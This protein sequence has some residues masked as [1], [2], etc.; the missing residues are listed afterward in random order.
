M[1]FEWEIDYINLDDLQL[2]LRLTYGSKHTIPMIIFDTGQLQGWKV[3]D[4]I[5]ANPG[6]MNP[7]RDMQKQMGMRMS[8][9]DYI[10]TN[11]RTGSQAVI[12]KND[13]ECEDAHAWLAELKKKGLVK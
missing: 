2:V 1:N 12:R 10:L 9:E 13:Y 5:D 3:G 4:R 6:A 8:E 11:Q 7:V